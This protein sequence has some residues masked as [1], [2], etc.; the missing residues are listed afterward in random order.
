MD[1]YYVG[2]LWF[3]DRLFQQR[4]G[5]SFNSRF[6]R[7]VENRRFML[8]WWRWLHICGWQIKGA[9]QVQGLSG[10]ML[11]AALTLS[12]KL[13]IIES[14]G[15]INLK[16]GRPIHKEISR[17]LVFKR[18]Y[19]KIKS[20]TNL[21]LHDFSGS[22]RWTGGFVAHTSRNRRFCCYTVRDRLFFMINKMYDWVLLS[23]SLG[24]FQSHLLKEIWI[25]Q[26]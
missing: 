2:W 5:D 25:K 26:N 7:V 20:K 13:E 21:L 18:T 8:H 10:E 9:H 6:T 24:F 1:S 19:Q 15:F 16:F 14:R 3:G 12:L 23:S 22:S 4:R 11:S 17:E